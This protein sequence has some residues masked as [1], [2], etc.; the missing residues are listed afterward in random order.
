[1]ILCAA[2]TVWFGLQ[3]GSVLTLPIGFHTIVL[4]GGFTI[5]LGAFAGG[6]IG[7][8]VPG[9]IVGLLTF[10]P[11]GALFLNEFFRH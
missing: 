4:I 2:I 1:M 9:A 3:A 6:L 5:C 7:H 11:L 10:L 8:F